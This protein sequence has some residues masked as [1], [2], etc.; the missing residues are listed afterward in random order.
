[1][2]KLRGEFPSGAPAWLQRLQA[3]PNYD[4][5]WDFLDPGY[6]ADRD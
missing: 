5:E 1:M 3:N 2:A 4:G 6:Y